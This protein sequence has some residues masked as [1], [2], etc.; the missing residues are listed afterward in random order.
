MR[1]RP[2]PAPSPLLP[3]PAVALA[4]ALLLAASLPF[5]PQNAAEP[6]SAAA[7]KR[8]PQSIW[9]FP[10]KGEH[11]YGGRAGRFGVK[12]ND[13]SIHTG[14]DVLAD[15]GRPLVAVHRAK[16]RARGYSSRTGHFLVLDGLGTK[17]D[18]VYAHMKGPA[19]QRRGT[20]VKAG[21]RVGSVG[22]TGSSI[23]VCH[24]HFELWSGNWYR[25]G[26]RVDPIKKL[27]AWDRFS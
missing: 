21:R 10:V 20:I 16:V 17:Y 27:R 3:A 22:R 26:K 6:T 4:L 18:F 15:C 11:D 19:R 13:G 14:Q 2:Q 5:V 12:R 9:R 25:G 23:G 7:A 24:L 1:P 8:G